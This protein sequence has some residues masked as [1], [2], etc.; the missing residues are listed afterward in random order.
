[1]RVLVKLLAYIGAFY[2]LIAVAGHLKVQPGVS[3]FMV[4]GFL[5]AFAAWRLIDGK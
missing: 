3:Q 1:M 4:I 2:V 5:A